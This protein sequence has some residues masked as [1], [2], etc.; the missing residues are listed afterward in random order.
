MYRLRYQ[1]GC[2]PT[3]LHIAPPLHF[4]ARFEFLFE[5]AIGV[6]A[7]RVISVGPPFAAGDPP[8]IILT[9]LSLSDLPCCLTMRTPCQ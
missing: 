4:L 7:C 3:A 9:L 2:W 8:I 1:P 6:S 5:E